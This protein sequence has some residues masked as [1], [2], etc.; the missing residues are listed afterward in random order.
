MHPQRI[1]EGV[2]T[3]YGHQGIKTEPLDH[4][5]RMTGQ[6]VGRLGCRGRQEGG[7][8]PLPHTPGVGPAAVEYRPAGPVDGPYGQAVEFYRVARNRVCVIRIDVEDC[9]PTPAQ[10]EHRMPGVIHPVDESLHDRVEARNVTAAGQDPYAHRHASIR[11]S[12][13]AGVP[14]RPEAADPSSTAPVSNATRWHRGQ[15][16]AFPG[17]GVP[18]PCEAP[19]P[20]SC[21]YR[22]P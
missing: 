7:H 14:A 8:V 21:G 13:S 1:R 15:R 18:S 19:Q 10:A 5:Y 6:V 16:I 4:P 11:G 20:R 9:A 22:R 2:V 12:R 3:A 17:S